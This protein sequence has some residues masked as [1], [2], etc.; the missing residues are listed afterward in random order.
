MARLSINKK[1]RTCHP[2]DHTVKIEESNKQIR[3]SCQRAEKTV[4]PESDAGTKVWKWD[5]GNWRLE[6]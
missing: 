3:R 2:A 1:K 6:E 4:E 5:I